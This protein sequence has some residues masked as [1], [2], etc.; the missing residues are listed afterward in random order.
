ME[1]EV[2]QHA[3]PAPPSAEPEL[4][5]PRRV[6][7]AGHELVIYVESPPLVAAMITDIQSAQRRVWLESYIFVND[8]VGIAVAEALKERAAAGVDVRVLY[9]AIGSQTTPTAFF[10]DLARAGARVHA[11]H[12]LGEALR[13]FSVFRVL[14]RRDHRKLLVIDD[15]VAYFGG[16]NL[17]DQTRAADL[18]D[19]ESLPSSAGWRDVHVR[20]TGPQQGEVAESFERSWQRAH[21]Q[22]IRRRS[23]S[24]RR[25]LLATGEESIQF[26]DSGPGPAHTRAAR[27]FTRLF[28]AAERRLTLSM[29]YFVP[30]GRVLRELLKAHRRGVFVRVVVPGR[31]DVPIVQYA[32]R[33]LYAK[34][35]RRRFHVYERQVN[36][37]HSK[38]MVVDDQWTV[39]GSANLDARSLWINL[40]FLAVIRSRNLARVMTEIVQFEIAQSRRITLKEYRQRSW[41]QRLRDRLAWSLRWSL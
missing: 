36:M 27:V 2:G 15:A 14:N 4:I 26:F 12:S 24:Y 10:R 7:I 29:A 33:Y 9:D 6:A 22:K 40:E 25:G 35:L 28:R 23:R 13:R 18:E 30:V 3:H 1:M 38:V 32:T 31:S 20:L 5:V 41:L 16:M 8:A 17:V 21:R 39:L 34:L 11:F 19:A 37:L